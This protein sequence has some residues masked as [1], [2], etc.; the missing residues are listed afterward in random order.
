M[1]ERVIKALTGWRGYALTLAGGVVA[2]A[3][4]IWYV[5]DLRLE[6]RDADLRTAQIRIDAL[7]SANQQAERDVADARKAVVELRREA[8]DR[9]KAAQDAQAQ[10]EQEI[11]GLESELAYWRDRPPAPGGACAAISDLR[12][13]Y[14]RGRGR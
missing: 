10:A 3:L 2:G 1:S 4:A 13:E 12:R 8:D 14:M 7:A 11:V 9:A 5:M 6:V